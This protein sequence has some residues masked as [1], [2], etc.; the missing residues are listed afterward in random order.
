MPMPRLFPPKIQG[1]KYTYD[2]KKYLYSLSKHWKLPFRYT[3]NFSILREVIAD[4]STLI[5]KRL[6]DNDYMV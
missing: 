6:V 4:F 5:L 3:E 1:K 2:I